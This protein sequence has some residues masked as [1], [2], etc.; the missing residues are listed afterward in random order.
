[1]IPRLVA[2]GDDNWCDREVRDRWGR[3]GDRKSVRSTKKVDL[4]RTYVL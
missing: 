3:S 2:G 4:F 1:L